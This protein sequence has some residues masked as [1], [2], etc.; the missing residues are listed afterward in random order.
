MW[1]MTHGMW[2]MTRDMWPLEGGEHSLQISGPLLIQFGN[3]GVLKIWSLDDTWLCM[4]EAYSIQ[5]KYLS[6]GNS[7]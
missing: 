4:N 1:H 2:H 3:E 7:G 6:V 5:N